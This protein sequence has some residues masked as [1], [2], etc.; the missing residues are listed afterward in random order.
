[1]IALA[2]RFFRAPRPAPTY[3]LR[4]NSMGDGDVPARLPGAAA[5]LPGRRAGTSCAPSTGSALDANPLRVLDC[6]RDACR[7]ATADAPALW[8]TTCATP[9]RGALRPGAAPA[10]TP[11]GSATRVD[12]R[13]VRGF[14][15]YTRTTFEF[16]SDALDSAQNGIGGGGRYDGLVELLGGPPTPGIGFGIGIERILLACDAEGVFPVDPA[17]RSTPSWSTPPGATPPG[18]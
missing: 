12:H 3:G 11:S 14:D 10:S 2:D 13:L 15:Y 17:A 6:K 5:R 1:M 18:T 16:A 7:A 4:L 9:C 8:P